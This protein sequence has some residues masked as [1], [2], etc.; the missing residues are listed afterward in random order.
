MFKI[1]KKFKFE[2]AHRLMSS[3]SLQCQNIHGHSYRA[4]VV[5][6]AKELNK[7]GVVID[8]KAL[9][10]T[11]G[12]LIDTLDHKLILCEKDSLVKTFKGDVDVVVVPYN[13]TAENMARD[14]VNAIMSHFAGLDP[15]FYS[16]SV[17][18]WET[19]TCW[20]EYELTEDEFFANKEN[21]NA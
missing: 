1:C 9:K 4:E 8:F 6:A 12:S 14:M 10:E 21:R 7:D 18:L 19:D 11:V 2:A 17:R 16:V 3:Y 13:P 15:A 20:A 5:L